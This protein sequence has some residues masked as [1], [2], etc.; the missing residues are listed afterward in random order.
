MRYPTVAAVVFL[1]QFVAPGGA[2][3]ADEA[4]CSG[5]A[6][7]ALS[8]S[9]DGCSWTNKG[10][11]SVRLAI[12]ATPAGAD[13]AGAANLSP[14]M[15]ILAPGETF[16]EPAEQC[17]KLAG[18]AVR[19]AASYPVL[20]E[21]AEETAAPVKP[22]LPKPKPVVAVVPAPVIPATAVAVATPAVMPVPRAKPAAP[23]AYP[24]LPRLKP[25]A[26]V[27][28]VAAIAPEAAVMP[29]AVAAPT[30]DAGGLG[31][32]PCTE[33]CGEILFKVI[34]SC[35][36]VQSQNPRPIA[37]E[38]TIAGK[39]M[40]LA[41][42]GADGAKADARAAAL[43][44]AGAEAANGAA[45]YHTRLHDPFQSSSPGLPVYRARLGAAGACVKSR[46]EIA[47]FSARFA[48]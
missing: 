48:K 19:Y 38:A 9:A 46:D 33:A 29:A 44:K 41:L 22:A 31:A 39:R 35:V 12:T 3:A 30:A 6:C 4:A 15:T 5:D 47:S 10:D 8:R 26:P 21:M 11:K 28:A 1:A 43:A 42:E 32:L 18:Y 34:D 27:A 17:S 23:P 16:K 2:S 24:P 25:E 14:M 13:A 40:V 7:G 20:R 45:A 37:F 36:W